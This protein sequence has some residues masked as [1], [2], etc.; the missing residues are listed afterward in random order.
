MSIGNIGLVLLSCL[1]HSY[2]NVLTQTSG[3]SQ[4]FSAL[5]GMWILAL[6]VTFQGLFDF[7]FFHP[8]ILFWGVVSGILHGLYIYCLSRAY[9]TQDIS[10]VY[11]IARSAPVFVPALAFVLLGERLTLSTLAAIFLIVLAI[12]ILHFE[13][14]LVQGFR[15]LFDAV[16]H[17]DLRWAFLTLGMVVCYS[18][19][20]KRGMD[21]FL[22]LYP[23]RF[24][25]NGIIFFFLESLVGFT[26]YNIY[27]WMVSPHREILQLWRA[28]WG[29]G[30][31]AGAATLGS[32]GT[33]CIVL[34]FEP[35]S[36]VVSLRQVS[37]LMVVYWGCWKLGEP[38]GQQ[39]LWAGALTVAGVGMMALNP[40]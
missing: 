20:D 2:W 28:E 14:H 13:G 23:D 9:H 34:Q 7:H 30:F 15:N 10:Y 22:Q 37:V 25:A 19:V 29:R 36:A 26:F 8:V 33:I 31:L 27:L 40:L 39:R 11:P 1:F 18:L 38:F 16:I 3:N 35:V 24:F 21:A 4:Y 5:K 17:K 6:A 12:Y 32:Y